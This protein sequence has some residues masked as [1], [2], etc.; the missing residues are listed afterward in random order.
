MKKIMLL[1]PLILLFCCTSKNGKKFQNNKVDYNSDTIRYS[2]SI[3]NRE[4]REK[5][6]GFYNKYGF[7]ISNF[8]EIVN[9]AFVDLDSNNT[10]DTIVILAPKNM[11]IPS[12][13]LECSKEEKSDRLLLISMGKVRKVYDNVICNDFG[14]AT[15]GIEN[16]EPIKSGFKLTNHIGQACFLDYEIHVKYYEKEF[17]IE[18]ITSISNCPGGAEKVLNKNYKQEE[19]NLAEYD[20]FFF[21]LK[22]R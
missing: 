12:E 3:I 4:C 19:F 22:L 5:S 6:I 14:N 21:N 17:Y 7:C 11:L 15:V 18:K 9:V 8:Y 1:L 13:N 20:R 2:S 10:N 16:I